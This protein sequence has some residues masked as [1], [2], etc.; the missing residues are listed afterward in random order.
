MGHAAAAM[1]RNVRKAQ[2]VL[3]AGVQMRIADYDDVPSLERAFNGITSLLFVASDGDGRDV[4]RHH[5]NVLNAAAASAI[6]HITFTSIVDVD[7][8]SPF[9]F[10][11]VYRDAERRLA[12][13]PVDSTVLR[14]GIYSD[15]LLSRWVQPALAT[16]RLSLP[17]RHA[18]IAPVSR[19]DVAEA[20]VAA[21]VFRER[22]GR[23]HELTGPTSYAFDEIAGLASRFSGAPI[24]YVSC[25][26]TEYLQR[27]WT[28]LP[29]P[30][31][32]AYT[33]LCASIAQGRYRRVSPDI[34][35]LLGRPAEGLD[36]FFQRSV[37]FPRRESS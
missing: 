20:A 18:G 32:H 11:P 37:T 28:E 5:A 3:P 23:V 27:L 8:T 4:M 29:D 35:H 19:D 17:V 7:E 12:Q 31:P 26:R 13:L 22:G 16:G 25:S 14:C 21:I 36:D 9:Y 2:H 24:K 1:A 34:E 10:S 33:T 6:E 30:W 15:F